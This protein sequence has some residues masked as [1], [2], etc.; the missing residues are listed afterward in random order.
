MQTWVWHKA[1]IYILSLE[2]FLR[3][4]Q[5]NTVSD[6]KYMYKICMQAFN[7][8]NFSF[9][10]YQP[11][12]LRRSQLHQIILTNI[13]DIC[14]EIHVQNMHA[15][16]QFCANLSVRLPL[17]IDAGRMKFHGILRIFQPNF[18]PAFFCPDYLEIKYHPQ[19]H[20]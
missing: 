18:S 9:K 19:N 14:H 12:M 15:C 7:S 4:I 11:W 8:L 13:D 3:L 2:S 1:K 5:S 10:L 16:I 20:G 17:S 6:M